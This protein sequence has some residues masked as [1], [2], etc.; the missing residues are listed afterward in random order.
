MSEKKH[1]SLKDIFKNSSSSSLNKL[2]HSSSP[3]SESNH[4]FFLR[5][6]NS[7]SSLTPSTSAS[8][9]KGQASSAGQSPAASD[10]EESSMSSSRKEKHRRRHD[11]HHHSHL[12]LKRFFKILRPEHLDGAQ[13]KDVKKP[14]E[15][16]LSSTS[17]LAKKYD[18]GKLIGTGASGS[19][20]LVTAHNNEK[21]I[22]AV[23]KFRA[24]LKNET[25]HDYQTKVKNEFLIGDYLKH[26]NL[27]HTMELIREKNEFLIVMEYCPY[28]FFNLVMSGL[29]KEEEVC[30]YFKQ[31]INGVAHLHGAGI[32]HRDLKLD[33]CV[34]NGD[35]VLKLIDFGSAFQYRK[36]S[37]ADASGQPKILKAKGIVGSDPYLAPEV[38]ETN[39][40]YDARLAD[41]WSIA[42]IFCCMILKRF[43]WKLPRS[44]D[45]SFRSFACLNNM[46]EPVTEQEMQEEDA[47]G[48][49]YGAE[50]L[51]RLLPKASRPLIQ[52]MLTI[53]C[54]KRFLIGDVLEDSFYHS[55]RHCYYAEVDEPEPIQQNP[56]DSFQDAPDASNG[57]P[58]QQNLDIPMSPEAASSP[59]S[60]LQSPVSSGSATPVI[61]SSQSDGIN[62]EQDHHRFGSQIHD[63]EAFA[64][65]KATKRV[66][67][68]FKSSNHKHHLITEQEL[69]KINQE[70]QRAK[71]MKENGVA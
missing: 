20:N 58:Q 52:G 9:G 51:L 25:D 2:G 15:L 21:E 66:E 27:I 18:I 60:Q 46:D 53:D 5:R 12:S 23:K 32:A 1:R 56:S 8:S 26:Q 57:S 37:K 42:I 69:E 28:D 71:K 16:P 33:N 17:D 19:V 62:Q 45:P 24:K 59:G 55:I 29:M 64:G 61:D 65:K 38:F 11:K 30:C 3:S 10:T 47:K 22:F 48:P 39:S 68:L 63:P 7:K 70:R 6:R 54:S 41:V 67:K 40:T 4:R 43:P 49:K 44:S 31:I 14:P 50:R 34:V 35:G 36:D 13:E